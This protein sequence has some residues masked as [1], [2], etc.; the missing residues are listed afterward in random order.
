MKRG[1]VRRWFGAGLTGAMF[2]LMLAVSVGPV[3]AADPLVVPVPGQDPQSPIQVVT[4]PQFGT[5]QLPGT[6]Q[7]G[8]VPVNTQ[9]Y[10][11]G[12]Y[13]YTGG[14]PVG[15]VPVNGQYFYYN[16]QYYD[17]NGN[18]IS[19]VPVGV[20]PI[21]VGGVPGFYGGFCNYGGYCGLT[22]AGPI[23]GYT[24]NGTTIVQDA[25]TGDLDTY[26][27]G[28]NGKYCEADVYGN[29]MKGTSCNP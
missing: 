9:Y 1:R 11:N 7:T 8:G 16:G 10:Y 5:G 17:A 2:V 4:S 28:S 19:G 6:V 26:V 14:V 12:Q 25:R 20:T 29:A 27:I 22:A 18:P 3:A 23:V 21:V 15:A 13:Y 24:N